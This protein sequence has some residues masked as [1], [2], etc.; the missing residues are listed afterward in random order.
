MANMEERVARIEK[1][2]RL[3]ELDKTWETSITRRVVISIFTY[4]SIGVF[5]TITEFERPW[6]AAIVPAIAFMLSMLIL[7]LF[8]NTWIRSRDKDE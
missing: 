2:N 1:R 7:P 4:L 5:L 3:V 6:V 8:K